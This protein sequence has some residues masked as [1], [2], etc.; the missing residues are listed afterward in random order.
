[1]ESVPHKNRTALITGGC[2]GLGRAIAETL[3]RRGA[4]VIVCD[5]KDAQLEDFK[6]KISAAYP[7]CT[8]VSKVDITDDAALKQLFTDGEERFGHIDIVINNA[9]I[10][11]KFDPIGEV[12]RVT[13]DRVMATNVTAPAMVSKLAINSFLEHGVKGAIVNI[14]SVAGV[15]GFVAGAA[16]TASKHALIG[17]TKNTGVFYGDRGIRCNAI[18]AGAMDTNIV[19]DVY[20][21]LNLGGLAMMNRTFPSDHQRLV[22]VE[23]VAQLASFLC[24]DASADLIN[25]KDPV[26][27][28]FFR[29]I[30]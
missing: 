11:D 8:L 14:S 23:K 13:W 21:T 16:Y 2:G 18:I 10:M 27:A 19:A 7:E 17:L 20:K 25:G 26:D 1:M 3:L 29:G 9:A 30:Y 15:R 4:N 22:D 12:D 5:V 24:S 6:E 28:M